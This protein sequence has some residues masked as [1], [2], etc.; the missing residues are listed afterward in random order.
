MWPQYLMA[1]AFVLFFVGLIAFLQMNVAPPKQKEQSSDNPATRSNEQPTKE[2]RTEGPA[3]AQPGILVDLSSDKLPNVAPPNGV[4]QMFEIREDVDGVHVLHLEKG[5][6]HAFPITYQFGPNEV[7]DW[8]KQLSDWPVLGVS[9]CE[10]TSITNEPIFD[11]TITVRFSFHE[12]APHAGEDVEVGT[13][14]VATMGVPGQMKSGPKVFTRDASFNV[15]K[16]S[17]QNPYVIYFVNRTRYL[18]IIEV[19]PTA[20]STDFS[21]PFDK[22]KREI[23]LKHGRLTGSILVTSRVPKVPIVPFSPKAMPEQK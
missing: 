22:M 2:V 9:K 19:P 21:R 6:V 10:L 4:I 23:L 18:T 14:I 11:A 20:I 13:V 3:T 17:S 1:F 12:M 15:S 16:I 7:I 5:D 8:R